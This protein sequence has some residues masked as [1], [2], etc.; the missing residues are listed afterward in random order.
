MPHVASRYCRD[1]GSSNAPL[2]GS[3]A[4]GVLPKISK[5]QS[6]PQKLGCILPVSS[7]WL[8]GLEGL[9]APA[10]FPSQTLRRPDSQMLGDQTAEHSTY[11]SPTRWPF[12]RCYPH[13]GGRFKANFSS[14]W[15]KLTPAHH[16]IVKTLE[17]VR[18]ETFLPH[19]SG[20]PGRLP[21]G[22][23]LTPISAAA[24]SPGSGC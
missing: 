1:D 15:K 21:V 7:S 19:W 22:S 14:G 3:T 6:F 8:G 5:M 13:G 10:S 12:R 17:M 2:R 18:L 24:S 4:T 11:R 16:D 20:L 23:E 9:D